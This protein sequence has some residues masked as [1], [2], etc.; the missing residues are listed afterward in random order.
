MSVNSTKK[1]PARMDHR[2]TTVTMPTL[3]SVVN[4]LSM[5]ADNQKDATAGRNASIYTP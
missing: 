3:R 2:E 1:D 4:T 5:V